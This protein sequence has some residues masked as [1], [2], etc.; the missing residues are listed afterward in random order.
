MSA[1]KRMQERLRQYIDESGSM[2][3]AAKTIGL[4]TTTLSLYLNGKYEGNIEKVESR[5]TEIFETAE[6]AG[7]LLSKANTVD[8]AETSISS[9]VY[10]T[11]R[12]C[13]L[14]GGIARESGDAGIGKTMAAKKYAKDYPNSAIYISVNPCT[15]SVFPC[16]RLIC[17]VLRLQEGKKDDM[18]YRI[19]NAL[20]GEKVLIIDEAQHMPIKTVE[21]LRALSDANPQLGICLIGNLET[22]GS[23]SKPAYAQIANR[24]KIKQIRLTQDIVYHDIELLCPALRGKKEINYLLN[25]AHSSQGLRGAVNVYSNAL[26]NRDIT[27]DGLVAMADAMKITLIGD[28]AV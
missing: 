12:L 20:A 13:H 15:A 23:S 28:Y 14:K 1:N 5:L 22:A 7:S 21:A 9:G 6:A 26:D 24:T 3:A 16:L 2:N 4:S 10:K 19:S 17:R 11:I 27:Y 18:W 8:Y 25:I